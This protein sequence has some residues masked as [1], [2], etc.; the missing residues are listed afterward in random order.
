MVSWPKEAGA[1]LGPAG[2]WN[3]FWRLGVHP[4]D[5]GRERLPDEPRE[6]IL[7]VPEL[8]EEDESLATKLH[9]WAEAGGWIVVAGGAKAF[10]EWR[11]LS[12]RSYCAP[13]RGFAY[14]GVSDDV[15]LVSPPRWPVVVAN[16][17]VQGECFGSLVEIHGER[18]TPGRAVITPVKGAAAVYSRGRIVFLNANPFSAFQAWLQ[19]Q[20]EVA[21]WFGWRHRLFWFDEQAV[22]VWKILKR[23]GLPLDELARPGIPGLGETTVVL[24]HDVDDSRDTSYLDT[25]LSHDV[26]AVHAI[27]DDHNSRFWIDKLAFCEDHEP[28]FHYNTIRKKRFSTR[29]IEKILPELNRPPEQYAPEYSQLTRGGL[30][31]QVENAKSL[32]IQSETI[33][34]HGPF[35]IYPELIE[36]LSELRSRFPGTLGSSSFFR[37]QVLRWGARRCDGGSGNVGEFPDA[38][39]AFWYPFRVGHAGNGGRIL[40]GWEMPCM[41]ECE[42]KLVEALIAYRIPEIKQRVFMLDYHPAHA[43]TSTFAEAGLQDAFRE[44]VEFLKNSQIGLLTLADVYSRAEAALRD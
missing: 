27:L 21:P 33:H 22:A 12:S 8:A 38:H 36:E 15:E 9:A 18:Q 39:Y 23:A 3:L 5:C 4:R 14:A 28:A 32:G 16:G 41:M 30:S 20:E 25:E 35:I 2:A 19:A 11:N 1:G 29:L 17:D 10:K 40:R 6:S 42:L 31:K 34:R 7:I 13:Y 44:I 26:A 43:N 24:R 37:G